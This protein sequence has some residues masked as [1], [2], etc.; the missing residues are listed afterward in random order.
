[1]VTRTSRSSANTRNAEN[2]DTARTNTVEVETETKDDELQ[3]KGDHE[4]EDPTDRDA[5]AAEILLSLSEAGPDDLED[6]VIEVYN[7]HGKVSGSGCISCS[8][9][10]QHTLPSRLPPQYIGPS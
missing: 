2:N 6:V 10:T 5:S 1:M 9:I 8:S 7:P 3:V 4:H